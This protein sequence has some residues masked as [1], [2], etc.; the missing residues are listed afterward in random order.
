VSVVVN[1]NESLVA[2]YTR[3]EEYAN[4]A[5]HGLG[6]ALSIAALVLMVA[7]AV[8]HGDPYHIVS[9]SIFGATLILLYLGSTLYH[10]ATHPETKHFL[11]VVD[12]SCIYLLIAGSYTPFT[13]VSLRGGWGWTLFGLT[14]GLALAGVVFKI[15]FTR[16][17]NLLSTMT[18]VALGW[19][20]V[21]AAKPMLTNVPT[22]ALAWLAAGGFMYTF[23]VV[24]Y[25]WRRIPY[26]HAIWHV[27]VMAGS[28]CHFLAVY[29][30][31]LP[32]L[33]A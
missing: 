19:L 4:I 6:V 2:R 21:I 27:M 25:L 33:S 11:R 3:R 9:V 8:K 26:H 16:R 22:G 23:G 18:Y 14:W 31:V 5:T 29:F 12:H 20:V 30:Y 24:F 1:S 7:Y 13:L 15:F 28:S 10:L 32:P 17:F